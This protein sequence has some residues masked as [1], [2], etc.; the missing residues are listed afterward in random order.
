MKKY[1]IFLAIK[2]IEIKNYT[3]IPSYPS[4]NGFHQ[5]NK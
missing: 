5:E 2:E 1:S 3:E 4:R